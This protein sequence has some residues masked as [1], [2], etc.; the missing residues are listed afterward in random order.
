MAIAS[1]PP[2]YN[3]AAVPVVAGREPLWLDNGMRRVATGLRSDI[4]EVLVTHLLD[5]SPDHR[6]AFPDPSIW[7]LLAALAT[8]AMFVGSIFTP[9]AVPIGAVPMF[10][11]FTGWFWPKADFPPEGGR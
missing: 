10:V 7:P 4:R 1:P 8:T 11:T 3:F 9:W 6:Y 2:P 5:A